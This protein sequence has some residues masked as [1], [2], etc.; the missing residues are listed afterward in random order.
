MEWPRSAIKSARPWSLFLFL[1]ATSPASQAVVLQFPV[2]NISRSNAVAT[3]PQRKALD[4]R[5]KPQSNSLPKHLPKPLSK[6]PPRLLPDFSLAD[7]SLAD[8]SLSS[9][10]SVDFPPTYQHCQRD[11]NASHRNGYEPDPSKAISRIFA[12]RETWHGISLIS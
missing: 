1:H 12:I 11:S 9:D 5:P 3:I 8:F 2:E 7:L 4:S 10:S 6:R